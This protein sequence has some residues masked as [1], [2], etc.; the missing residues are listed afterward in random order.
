MKFEIIEIIEY[1]FDKNNYFKQK[2]N[3]NIFYFN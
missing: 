3:F 2:F 1:F